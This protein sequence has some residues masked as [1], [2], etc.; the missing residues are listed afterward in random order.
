MIIRVACTVVRYGDI[1]GLVYENLESTRVRLN[2]LC[3]VSIYGIIGDGYVVCQKRLNAG[4]AVIVNCVVLDR[5]PP[6]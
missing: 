2:M 1:V 6:V 4:T 5:N 3:I